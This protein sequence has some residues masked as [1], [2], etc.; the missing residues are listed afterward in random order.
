MET[1]KRAL[2]ESETATCTMLFITAGLSWSMISIMG[3]SS[4]WKATPQ[5]QTLSGHVTGVI[6][7]LF[8][9]RGAF[10][11]VTPFVPEMI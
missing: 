6:K 8:D 1:R 5:V 9:K 10:F 2:T 7:G 11:H 3:L 4:S